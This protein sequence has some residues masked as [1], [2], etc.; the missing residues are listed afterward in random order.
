MPKAQQ[1]R[2]LSREELRAAILICFRSAEEL[3]ADAE[4]L[5]SGKRYARAIFL[6]CIGV[7]ELGKAALCLELYEANWVFDSDEKTTNF[8]NFWR[9]HM[10]KAAH[11]DGYL[12]LN[13]D[14][15]EEMAPDL[16]PEGCSSW[17]EFEED[18]REFYGSRAIASLIVKAASLYV[19]FRER[20]EK[21]FSFRLPSAYWKENHATLYI[22]K[23]A[24]RIED[25]QVRVKQIGWLNAPP[26]PPDF[27]FHEDFLRDEE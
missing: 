6:A 26:Y 8:W 24:Q 2:A 14:V 21:G 17:R 10:G 20:G 7:E 9:H 18:K 15:L 12:E 19:D 23:L 16:V 4:L 1:P 22:T 11:G 13:V 25:M 5:Y 3:L 27:D